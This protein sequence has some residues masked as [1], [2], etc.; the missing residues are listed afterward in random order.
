[1]PQR[2]KREHR[3][4]ISPTPLLRGPGFAKKKSA[5]PYLYLLM[6]IPPTPRIQC[7]VNESVSGLAKKKSE[8]AEMLGSGL[9]A[10]LCIGEGGVPLVD[11]L[12]AADFFSANPGII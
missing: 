1:M 3:E 11:G 8:R 6:R 5:R 2:A 9:E 4:K 12:S 7:C 10:T